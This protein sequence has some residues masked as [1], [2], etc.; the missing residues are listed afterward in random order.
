MWLKSRRDA[1]TVR[2][3]DEQPKAQRLIRAL[4]V[5]VPLHTDTWWLPGL[6]QLQQLRV[7]DE[8]RL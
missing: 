3:T 2:L 8:E 7:T 4:R 6:L 5:S 1:L